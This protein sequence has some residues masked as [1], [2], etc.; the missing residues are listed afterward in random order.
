MVSIEV[1]GVRVEAD[2]L[3][4]AQKLAKKEEKRQARVEKERLGKV[5]RAKVFAF[6][7]IGKLAQSPNRR[8]WLYPATASWIRTDN[9]YWYVRG[10]DEQSPVEYTVAAHPTCLLRRI[11][12]PVYGVR[13]QYTVGDFY[14]LALGSFEGVTTYEVFPD[15]L[16]AVL[17]A[18]YQS[19]PKDSFWF[20][21]AQQAA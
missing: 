8:N 4:D 19:E 2:T 20:A 13:I 6:A 14:W 18:Q 12:G 10:G 15:S 7:E 1:N 16:A 3:K 9:R 5:D 17:E 21:D 11:D